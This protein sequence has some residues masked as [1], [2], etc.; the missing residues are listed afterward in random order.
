M[1]LETFEK[2]IKAWNEIN[3]DVPEYRRYQD[4]V[5]GLKMNKEVKGLSS[6]VND[7]ILKVLERKEDQTVIKILDCLGKK[8]GRLRLEETEE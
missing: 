5:E 1:S 3:R 8:F 7:H 2:E 4:M 6:Y